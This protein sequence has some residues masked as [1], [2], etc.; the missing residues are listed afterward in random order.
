[1]EAAKERSCISKTLASK[2]FYSMFVGY[3]LPYLE[4]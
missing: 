2:R 3:L 1:M 4:N